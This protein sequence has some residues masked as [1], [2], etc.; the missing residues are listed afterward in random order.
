[1]N[2]EGQHPVSL[3]AGSNLVRDPSGATM[4]WNGDDHLR[5]FQAEQ[6]R[7][8]PLTRYLQTLYRRRWVVIACI[9]IAI[10]FA[11]FATM[12]TTPL[13]RATMTLEVARE[14]SKVVDMQGVEPTMAAPSQEF[15]QTQYGLLKSRSLADMVVRRLKLSENPTLLYGYGG[16]PPTT[17]TSRAQRE[18]RAADVVAANLTVTPVRASSLVSI[19]F[20]SPDPQ[21]SA[22]VVNAL[23][24]SF[25]E[26]NLARRFNASAYARRFLEGRLAAVRKRLEDSERKLVEYASQQR[27]INLDNGGNSNSSTAAGGQSLAGAEL[28]ALTDS[29]AAARA[30]R[31]AAEARFSQTPRNSDLANTQALQ[32][33][34]ISNLRAER[35]RLSSQYSKALQT[36]RPDYPDMVATRAQIADIDQQIARMARQVGGSIRTDYEVARQ[37]EAQL[38]ARVDGLKNNV[39]D[40]R[41]RSI[42]YDII[43]RDADTNR[44]LY[45]GLLQRYK[46][47]GIAGGVGNNNV[48]VVDKARV[49]KSPY[50]PK[51]M[52]NLIVGL[53]VGLLAGLF[54]AFLVDQLDESIIA[55]DSLEADL[56]MPLLGAIPLIDKNV[57]AREALEART[58]PLSEAYLSA[59]TALRFSTRDGAPKSL[60]VT[61]SRAHE[62]KSTT[63]L[64]I[65]R[66]FATLGQSVILVD[67]DMRDPSVHKMLGLRNERGLSDALVGDADIE[68]LIQNGG[69]ERLWVV[70]SG[71][72]APNPSE[73]LA[74]PRFAQF[75][76]HLLERVDHV[77]IDGP[78]VLGIAD[79]PL[80]ASYVN[81]T[82]FV[83]AAKGTRRKEVRLALRRLA[84]V[85]AHVIGAILTKFNA[86]STGYGY[87]A[88]YDYRYG[89]G[90]V[91]LLRSE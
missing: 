50:T 47:I 84:K 55:P 12:T 10:G 85:Q 80:I 44:S 68:H 88:G 11:M 87:G 38:Q 2:S 86:R 39:L 91:S 33:P 89:S 51:P 67:G 28:A 8:S 49:P 35:A 24:E 19:A 53:L 26:S 37:R 75:I 62:G 30:D 22:R 34:A 77:V 9:A 25:I 31:V 58:S 78:P 36:Y 3:R 66:N 21:L 48:S 74:G 29:L 5:D 15:Y 82:L 83:I 61:S 72:L 41:R 20:D 52:L 71:S 32:D 79:A 59:Q 45:E 14:A 73:L 43:Q 64:A 56:G 90:K 46:E 70:T 16:K 6:D 42:Q 23:G 57:E 69:S 65:A 7:E 17:A 27:I 76:A 18:Q 60:L 4:W 40:V 1:M 54:F 63:A 81:G 13:Y